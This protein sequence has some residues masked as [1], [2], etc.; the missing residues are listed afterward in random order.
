MAEKTRIIRMLQLMKYLSG[1]TMRTVDE[2]AERLQLSCRSIYRY[3]DD[4][5]EA[6]FAVNKIVSGIYSMPAIECLEGFDLS[7]LVY[8]TEEEAYL[9][10]SLIDSLTDD[11]ALKNGLKKKLVSLC[12]GTCISEYVGRSSNSS[13][14]SK[15]A[16]A[17]KEEKKV[18]FH[19]YK[20]SHSGEIRNRFVEPFGLIPNDVEAWAYDLEDGQNKLF[21]IS[22]IESVE[23]LDE[24][25]TRVHLHQK[26][27][28]DPFRMAS[29]SPI[30]VRF[31]MTLMAYN[32]LLEEFP[33]A[34]KYVRKEGDRW[35]FDGDV[36]RLEGVGRFVIGL[37]AE[38][39][40]IDSPNLTEYV[41]HY[42]QYITS[43]FG[44]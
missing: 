1:N 29:F 35:V 12:S 16:E 44:K 6:G 26:G 27:Y 30:P 5:K 8:F 20:S 37:A 19:G 41:S 42:S 17:I 10:N 9:V 2:L 14:V 22:R 13:N 31:S 4:F 32:L 7:K 36:A 39:D 18:I 34:E 15:I 40:I 11:N 33:M 25:W 38:I 28:L 3:M 21:R 43:L 24:R 23:V